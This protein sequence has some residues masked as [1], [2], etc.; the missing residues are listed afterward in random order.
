MTS[1]ITKLKH[2]NAWNCCVGGF[3]IIAVG[4]KEAGWLPRNSEEW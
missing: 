3:V 4:V 2:L 1:H